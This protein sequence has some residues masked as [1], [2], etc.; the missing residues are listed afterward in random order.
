MS[1][2]E[3]I[4]F[5]GVKN[6]ISPI[7]VNKTINLNSF[8]AMDIETIDY[9]GVQLPILITL[10]YSK[11]SYDLHKN[12]SYIMQEPILF[13]MESSYIKNY[14]YIRGSQRMFNKFFKFV[15]KNKINNIFTHNLGSFDGYFIIK[16][17]TTYLKNSAVHVNTLIDKQHRFITINYK[18]KKVNIEFR[19]SLR[20]T[21]LSLDNLCKTFLPEHL[22]KGTYVKE[23]NTTKVFTNLHYTKFKTYSLLDSQV[24]YK[25][26]EVIQQSYFKLFNIDITLHYSSSQLSFNIFRRLFLD[27]DIELLDRFDN[28]Y[29]KDSYFGGHTD[30]FKHRIEKGYYYDVNSL[31]PAAMKQLIPIKILHKVHGDRKPVEDIFGFIKVEVDS[32]NVNKPMLPYR[33]EGKVIYPKGKFIGTYFSEELKAMIPLGYKFNVISY[34]E[35]EGAYIFN[36]YVDHFYSEKKNAT[37]GYRWIVKMHLNQLYG[38]FGRSL[39]IFYSIILPQDKLNTIFSNVNIQVNRTVTLSDDLTLLV[40]EDIFDITKTNA[41]YNKKVL[42]NVMVASAVTSY[43]RLIMLPYLLNDSVAYTDTDSIITTK[44]LDT[45]LI[46]KELGQM[47]DELNGGIILEGYVF[48]IKQYVLQIKDKQGNISDK[49]VWAGIK[50]NTITLSEAKELSNQGQGTG[51]NLHKDVDN[52]FLHDNSTLNITIKDLKRTVSFN[53]LKVLTGNI[54]KTTKI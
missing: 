52:V 22:R 36:K 5:R 44:P 4:K 18:T 53:S 38:Y 43:A 46:G 54:F 11:V 16:A 20:L 23:W 14:E 37:G 21:G 27:Q 33:Y 35:C 15:I 10:T 49:S 32:S 29:I 17:L 30:Y 28:N 1:N 19:D 7:Q 9:K 34:I 50:R 51:Y 47:K 40:C 26:L 41:H 39:D 3:N 48:G 2:I 13:E 42:A 24:L 8:A 45:N 6:T 25:C 31:Y 12:K